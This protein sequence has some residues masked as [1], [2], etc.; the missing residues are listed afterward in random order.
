M[1][2]ACNDVMLFDQVLDWCHS[3]F[4]F[5]KFV[6]GVLWVRSMFGCLFGILRKCQMD[7]WQRFSFALCAQV[8]T[9][10]DVA[11]ET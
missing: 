5:Q 11:T 8:S 1:E 2:D 9:A 6:Y 3:F 7:I 4:H 10:T